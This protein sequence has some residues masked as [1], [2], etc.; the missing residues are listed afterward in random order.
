M[1]AKN[2]SNFVYRH[3]G[4]NDSDIKKMLDYLGIKSLDHLIKKVIPKKILSPITENLLEKDLSEI[5][6]LTCL[7]DYS[8]K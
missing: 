2:K 1:A 3:V 8:N 7:K 4:P 6:A 5:E